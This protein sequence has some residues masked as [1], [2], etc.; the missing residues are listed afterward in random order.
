MFGVVEQ[1]MGFFKH[2]REQSVCDERG[3]EVRGE[4]L[5]AASKGIPREMLIR[6]TKSSRRTERTMKVRMGGE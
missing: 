2:G 6:V 4:C 5:G 1:S 3:V